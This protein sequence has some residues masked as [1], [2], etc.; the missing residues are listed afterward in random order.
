MIIKKWKYSVYA[1]C[2]H[3]LLEYMD[4]Q[5]FL[6]KIGLDQIES[7]NLFRLNLVNDILNISRI[8]SGKL[9]LRFGTLDFAQLLFSLDSLFHT[10]ALKKGIT[11]RL[12]DNRIKKRPLREDHLWLN[13]ALVNI[14][15]NAIKFTDQG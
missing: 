1:L 10:Q 13:Q 15:R 3:F 11:I 7:S 8:E 14:I 4:I 12:E 6:F 2:F 9:E 5:V